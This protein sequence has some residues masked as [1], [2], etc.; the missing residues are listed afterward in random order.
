M[1]FT[2]DHI[3]GS[4]SSANTI[5]LI[6]SNYVD[7]CRNDLLYCSELGVCICRPGTY[8]SPEH[9]P[10]CQ[11]IPDGHNGTLVM[12]LGHPSCS[13]GFVWDPMRFRC[14]RQRSV[15]VWVDGAASYDRN[16]YSLFFAILL[17]LLLMIIL[18]KS[19]KAHMSNPFGSYSSRRVSRASYGD[20]PP[21]SDLFPQWS[22]LGTGMGTSSLAHHHHHQSSSH[23]P[24]LPPATAS[25]VPSPDLNGND[26]LRGTHCP[27]PPQPPP[28]PPYSS[29]LNLCPGSMMMEKPPPYEEAIYMPDSPIPVPTFA[30]HH[31]HPGGIGCPMEITDV[32]SDCSGHSTATATPGVYY[33][34]PSCRTPDYGVRGGLRRHSTRSHVTRHTES[35]ASAHRSVSYRPSNFGLPGTGIRRSS[36]EGLSNGIGQHRD[37][38][39]RGSMST[40]C[41]E[42]LVSSSTSEEE[43]NQPSRSEVHLECPSNQEN[44]VMMR[45][46]ISC[47]DNTKV[48]EDDNG[49]EPSE[50]FRT[51][52]DGVC[53]SSTRDDDE[54]HD[55]ECLSR[56]DGKE[57]TSGEDH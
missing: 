51:T 17:I 13:A 25:P 41:N 33:F 11:P 19:K 26:L 47:E 29:T 22:H 1:I 45:E 31:H 21:S 53:L 48:V 24:R 7:A 5:N 6:G 49:P 40:L 43:D 27:Y 12:T 32:C 2:T 10:Y 57:G 39:L 36:M 9:T 38:G 44:G 34:R 15:A 35:L 20:G 50:S 52:E 42:P 8:Y 56:S 14:V 54:K 28:P 3:D 18:F 37:D 30:H 4:S 46:T 55:G 23:I 16:R